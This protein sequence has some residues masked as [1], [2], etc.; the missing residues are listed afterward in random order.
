AARIDSVFAAYQRTAGPG[1]AVGVYRNGQVAYSRGYGMADLNQGIAI[2]PQTRFYIASTS[3]QFAAASLTLLA[4]QGKVSLDDPV[5]KY[6][7]ELPAYANAITLNHLVHHGSGLRDYLGLWAFSGRSMADQIP[8]EAA[9]DLIARQKALDF[10]PGTRWAYSNSGYFLISV[11]VKRASGTSLRE[12]AR[13]NIFEPLGMQDTHFHD[14]HAMVV[15]HRAEGYEPDG[16]GGYRIFRTSYALVGDGGLYST[17]DDLAKWDENFFTNR[18]GGGGP[19]LIRALTTR[20]VLASGDTTDYASGLF[21]QSYRGVPIV[22]HGGSF[23]GYRA[24][25]LRF[26]TE[27]TSIAVLCNDYTA[28][29]EALAKQV[30]DVVLVARFESAAANPGTTTA[31]ARTASEAVLSRYPGRY[32]LM[33]GVVG[34]VERSGSALVLS[35]FGQKMTLAA[36]SDS[37]FDTPGLPGT[38]TFRKLPNGRTGLM[39]PALGLEVPAPPLSP[40]PVLSSADRRALVGRYASEELMAT[41]VVKDVNGKLMVRAGYGDWLPLQPFQRDQFTAGAAKVTVARNAA[42]RVAGMRLDGG[43]MRNIQLLRTGSS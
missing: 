34:T 40:V 12:F 17:I 39:A 43:R 4:M 5:R 9:L 31:P 33:P 19:A 10:A 13:A 2:T 8:E 38:F 37:T 41:F 23:I 15:P 1:C 21:V 20:A 14:D 30:A 22:S 32:E 36:R 18:L 16:K 25:L 7:P 28:A 26:P 35:V 42:G 3:K 24:E 27:H 6:I 11:V 29:T